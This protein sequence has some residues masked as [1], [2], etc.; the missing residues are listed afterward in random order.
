MQIG[1]VTTPFGRRPMTLGMLTNQLNARE[2]TPTKSVDKW[3]LFRSLCEARKV[4]GV[5]DRALAVLNALLSFYPKTELSD[6]NGLVVF[7]SNTQLS[8]RTHGMADTTLRRHLAALVDAGLIFRKDSPNGK[9]YARK[10][11]GGAISVAFGFSL[12][13]LLAR[14]QQIE[15]LAAEMVAQRQLDKHLKEQVSLCRRDIAK[16]IEAA[17][18]EGIAGDW[19]DVQLQFDALTVALPR[20]PQTAELSSLLNNLEAFRDEI[21]KCLETYVNASNE[22]A[23]DSHIGGHIQSSDTNPISE[24]ERGVPTG[25][26][27]HDPAIKPKSLPLSK[28]YSL[29]MVLQACPEIAMYGPTGSISSWRDL[30]VAGQVVRST[31]AVSAAAYQK[32]YEVMGPENASTVI[33]CILER[34]DQISSPGGYLR[35]LTRKAESGAFSLGPMLMALLRGRANNAKLAA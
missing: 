3:K 8:L 28:A 27:P 2:M 15:Q 17:R 14:A 9:R 29:D 16:L 24:S 23:N 6:E 20:S 7:P 31:L 33:A 30:I 22:S 5:S 4:I 21:V 34:V 26:E 10:G 18:H 13:P 1:S 32:A 35:D 12:A 19:Q 25:A 11:R